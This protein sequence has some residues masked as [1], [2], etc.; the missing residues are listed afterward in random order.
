MSGFILCA[1]DYGM[2]LGVSKAILS[3]ASH[4]RLSAVGCMTNFAKWHEYAKEIVPLSGV[5]DIGIHLNLTLGSPLERDQPAFSPAGILLRRAVLGQLDG[6]SIEREINAQCIAFEDAM[7]KKPDFIDGHQHVH[8]LPIIRQALMRVIIKRYKD[9]KPW[10]RDPSDKVTSIMRRG[11]ATS[12]AMTVKGLAF[13]FA[14]L[15]KAS[16]IPTNQGFS[17]FSAFDV[18]RDFGDD[19]ERFLISTGNKHLIMCHP[20]FIDD[21]LRTLDPVVETRRQEYEFLFGS[22]FDEIRNKSGSHLIR[23]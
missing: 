23:F 13:G 6:K 16:N 22:R 1:D 2:T 8:A 10:L 7:Q 14:N 5:I 21:E 19:F 20:G 18:R 3:L 11:A 4:K 12:K 9:K 17:G 15:A